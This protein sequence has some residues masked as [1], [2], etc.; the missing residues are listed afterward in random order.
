MRP[1][2]PAI[3]T[4]KRRL[5]CI[6]RANRPAKTRPQPARICRL[7]D[8][9]PFW[10]FPKRRTLAAGCLCSRRMPIQISP[11]RPAGFCGFRG[12]QSPV[13]RFAAAKR[14]PCFEQFARVDHPF[15]PCTSAK[16]FAAFIRQIVFSIILRPGL[17]PQG[18]KKRAR[19]RRCPL[20]LAE[21]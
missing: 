11:A 10:A 14:L 15:H 7:P 20:F 21:A 18:R 13:F 5:R 1:T 2:S 19:A 9:P 12:I 17:P 3:H 4:P 8:L 16:T 6:R